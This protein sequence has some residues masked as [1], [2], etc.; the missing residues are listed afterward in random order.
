MP[1]TIFTLSLPTLLL[2]TLTYILILSILTFTYTTLRTRTLLETTSDLN[3]RLRRQE[4]LSVLLNRHLQRL[5]WWTWMCDEDMKHR[6]IPHLNYASGVFDGEKEYNFPTS[7]FANSSSSSSSSEPFEP[8]FEPPFEGFPEPGA[9]QRE[10]AQVLS[11]LEQERREGG[12]E[13]M[14]RPRWWRCGVHGE[15]ACEGL[16][17]GGLAERESRRFRAPEYVGLSSSDEDED[18]DDD[19]RGRRRVEKSAVEGQDGE[20][21]SD[22]GAVIL[23]AEEGEK[24]DG[25]LTD[26]LRNLDVTNTPPSDAHSSSSTITPLSQS[27]QSTGHHPVFGPADEFADELEPEPT[28]GNI[29]FSEWD[30]IRFVPCYKSP[31]SSAWRETLEREARLKYGKPRIHSTPSSTG[32]CTF[33]PNLPKILWDQ[34]RQP[35]VTLRQVMGNGVELGRY[36]DR[37][38]YLPN[39][40]AH[41][42]DVRLWI[43]TTAQARA[44]RRK[45]QGGKGKSQGGKG[46]VLDTDWEVARRSVNAWWGDVMNEDGTKRDMGRPP[47]LGKGVEAE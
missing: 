22:T 20:V 16:R 23:D 36:G 1:T 43:E 34:P 13:E 17:G 8:P 47:G 33:I 2:L 44:E 41:V 39:G 7:T 12:A 40:W 3:D 28:C 15:C 32:N 31:P 46:K 38:V 42:V 10:Y 6:R 5:T 25:D 35:P 21:R 19:W 9:A 11:R 26:Q 27:E 37:L 18:E 24:K 14:W 4:R 29:P 45:S 30:E